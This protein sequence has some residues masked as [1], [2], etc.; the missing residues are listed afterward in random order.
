MLP[1]KASRLPRLKRLRSRLARKATATPYPGPSSTAHSTFTM[2]CTGAHWLPNTGN[3][4]M[5]PT[6]ATAVNMPARAIFITNLF[7]I[8]NVSFDPSEL[9]REKTARNS[10]SPLPGKVRADSA[11]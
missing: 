5:L 3:W 1:G 4:S 7:L 6:T 10:V 9:R 11:R 8:V 2:C